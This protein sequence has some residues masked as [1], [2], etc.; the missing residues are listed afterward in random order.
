MGLFDFFKSKKD[1]FTDNG[2][3]YL[4][5]SNG[6]LKEQFTKNN[7]VLQGN[8]FKYDEY[9]CIPFCI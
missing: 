9:V 7:G 2:T 6:K 4:Y 8:Y 5:Y 3:N 1:V